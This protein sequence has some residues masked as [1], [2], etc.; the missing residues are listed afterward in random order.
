M[1]APT[2]LQIYRRAIKEGERRLSATGLELV[3]TGFNAG[4]TIVFGVAALGV[5]HALVEP[6]FGSE[7]AKLAGAAGFGIGL[8]FLVTS[9]AELFTENFFDPVATVFHRQ[10][11]RLVL[12]LLRLWIVVLALNLIG[13]AIFVLVLSVDGVLPPGSERALR[14]VAEEIA[15]KD[16]TAALANAVVG[17]ALVTLLS[18]LLQAVDQVLSRMVAAYLVGFLLAAGPFAHVVVTALHLLFGAMVGAPVGADDIAA[19]TGI[20]IVGN[21]VGGLAF[22]TLTH[23]AQARGEREVEDPDGVSA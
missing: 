19:E 5:V 14:A 15:A 13:G 10:E 18:F 6:T 21:L 23:M 11:G 2:P 3:A 17:G 12:K 7:T 4:L 16:V 22:V 9:R 20:A 8:L 1:V